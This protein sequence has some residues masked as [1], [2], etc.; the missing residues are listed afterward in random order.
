MAPDGGKADGRDHYHDEIRHPVRKHADGSRFVA[1]PQRL[2]FRRVRPGHREDAQREA[3]EEEKHERDGCSRGGEAVL[4][5]CAGDDGHAGCAAGGREHDAHPAADPV[6]VEVWRPGEEGVLSEG[7]RGE[8]E[9]H[10]GGVA[11]VVLEDDSEI[12]AQCIHAAP[13]VEEVWAH[14][15]DHA[16]Q[17]ACLGGVAENF[18]PA[19]FFE[20]GF[21][22][23]G[24]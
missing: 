11:E 21:G 2:D 17:V 13:L 5:E 22:F 24:D 9:G 8:D 19:G 16:V 7:Y 1:H 15:E 4:C 10:A 23:D 14:A 20:L 18:G 12:V 6:D 3:V